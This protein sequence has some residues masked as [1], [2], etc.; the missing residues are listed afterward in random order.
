MKSEL[1]ILKEIIIYDNKVRDSD[2]YYALPIDLRKEIADKIKEL[3]EEICKK[4]T[5][6]MG[7]N[8]RFD[9]SEYHQ[10][11]HSEIPIC[12]F[13]GCKPLDNENRG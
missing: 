12:V 4:P 1:E 8:R 5:R 6:I 7:A 10:K 13:A 2:D 11:E 3:E 9:I